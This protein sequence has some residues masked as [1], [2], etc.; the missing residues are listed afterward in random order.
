MLSPNNFS[1]TLMPCFFDK[2]CISSFPSP[3]SQ[4]LARGQTKQS[5]SRVSPCVCCFVLCGLEKRVSQQVSRPPF[6]WEYLLE[7]HI[8]KTERPSQD[9]FFSQNK[10]REISLKNKRLLDDYLFTSIYFREHWLENK[11]RFLDFPVGAWYKTGGFSERGFYWHY[12]EK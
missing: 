2:L 10:P 12:L 3:S 4:K 8:F 11:L 9:W 5:A 6:F 7:N 1:T